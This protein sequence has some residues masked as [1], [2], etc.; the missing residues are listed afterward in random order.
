M[1]VDLHNKGGVSILYSGTGAIFEEEFDP[2]YFDDI[3][4]MIRFNASDTDAVPAPPIIF[5]SYVYKNGKYWPK[6]YLYNRG[7]RDFNKFRIYK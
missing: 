1:A 3:E 2:E 4:S 7:D 5:K 6:L